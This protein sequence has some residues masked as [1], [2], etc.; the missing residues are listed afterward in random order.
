MPVPR[1]NHSE[2]GK[3][4]ITTKLFFEIQKTN[5]NHQNDMKKH[6]IL[7]LFAFFGL[8]IQAQSAFTLT[9]G[10]PVI[11][12]SLPKTELKIDIET[13]KTVQ[14]PGIF[15]RYSERYLATNKVIT[16]E[17]TTYRLKSLKV[18]THALADETR[19]FSYVPGNQSSSSHLSV[20]AQGILCGLN[21]ACEPEKIQ[22]L[23]VE[24]SAKESPKTDLLPL[25]EEYM[26][27][28]SE[29]K[30]A[31]GVAKQIY[32]IRERRL[33]LLTAD[34]D[35]LPNDGESFK[36]MLDG[37]AKTEK[38]LT[39]L[40][41]G[42]TIQETQ[43]QTIGITPMEA[44]KGQVLFRLSALKGIVSSDDLSGAPY[45]ISVLPA[46]IAVAAPDPKSK[47]EKPTFY[48][49]LPSLTKVSIG[50]GSNT[51]Y[52]NN[53]YFPQ[54]GKTVPVA[55][56]ML[57]QAHVKVHIDPQTGRLLSIE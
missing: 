31:E 40:F 1:K 48:Y 2:K 53:F 14:R 30:L 8:Y 19:T 9:E 29:A 23:P 46:T 35:K 34:V 17:K 25:G 3:S 22:V 42:K 36:T 7:I 55:E 52:S 24:F 47:P 38:E 32:R 12:Y 6:L 45:Y 26:M 44:M 4:N 37:L 56:S 51:L 41:V 20:N 33:S 10:E 5:E 21:V 54:F 39:E 27:A 50:D 57:K 49:I 16:Q 28:G 43:S 15:Y 13:E 18:N 11:V